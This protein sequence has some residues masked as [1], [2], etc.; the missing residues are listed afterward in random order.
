MNTKDCIAELEARNAKLVTELESLIKEWQKTWDLLTPMNAA[1]NLKL[2]EQFECVAQ[3]KHRA[4]SNFDSYERV[5][6]LYSASQT[7]NS[8]LREAWSDAVLSLAELEAHMR[9]NGDILGADS[10]ISIRRALANACAP[11][12]E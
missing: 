6:A 9:S 11:L 7:E 8:R 1:K 2:E 4:D 3:E 5:K 10:L 12:D